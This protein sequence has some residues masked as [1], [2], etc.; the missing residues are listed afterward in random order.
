MPRHNFANFEKY[1]NLS[2]TK[3]KIELN[4]LREDMLRS[5]NIKSAADWQKCQDK[6]EELQAV[7][8][9][10][11]WQNRREGKPSTRQ[12]KTMQVGN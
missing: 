9:F 12:N 8:A 10:K 2:L 1:A 11:Q 3:V 5:G 4:L 6:R 7:V